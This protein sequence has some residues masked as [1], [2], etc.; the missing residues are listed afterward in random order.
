MGTC[1]SVVSDASASLKTCQLEHTLAK[2][3]VFQ[4]DATSG[5]AC[6]SDRG[7]EQR[8]CAPD[9][10]VRFA[11]ADGDAK[12]ATRGRRAVYHHGDENFHPPRIYSLQNPPY[13]FRARRCA[14]CFD[15]AEA[16]ETLR[17]VEFDAYERDEF[18]RLPLFH[19]MRYENRLRKA[20]VRA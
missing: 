3:F 2:T 16:R 4:A 14:E 9:S 7:V 15:P 6:V 17:G 8:V 10:G 11:T 12:D 20:A 18:S 1:V 19:T 5:L 13:L